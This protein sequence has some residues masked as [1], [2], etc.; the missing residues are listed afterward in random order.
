MSL[1]S[2]VEVLYWIYQGSVRVCAA[3]S[4]GGKRGKVRAGAIEVAN[5]NIP[6]KRVPMFNGIGY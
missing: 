6:E 2:F 1:A 3:A 4:T 5:G